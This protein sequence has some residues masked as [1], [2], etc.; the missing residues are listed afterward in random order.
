MVSVAEYLNI[1]QDDNVVKRFHEIFE[2]MIALLIKEVI[3]PLETR[4]G[5]LSTNVGKLQKELENRNLVIDELQRDKVNL[6]DQLRAAK[7]SISNM[8]QYSRRDN[9]LITGIPATIADVASGEDDRDTADSSTSAMKAVLQT[10]K[11][12]LGIDLFIHAI[13]TAHHLRSRNGSAPILVKFTRRADRDLIYS[14]RFS[15]KT[16]NAGVPTSQKIFINEDLVDSNRRILNAARQHV[17]DRKIK[18]VWSSMCRVR[19][20]CLDDSIHAVDSNQKLVQLMH[21]HSTPVF[22]E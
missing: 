21:D 6:N 12:H 11:N 1:L 2:G 15:L 16:H 8:E 14:K 20:R 7:V 19:I 9:L 4:I 18:G 10:C 22:D 13:S 17:H 3:K 5:E